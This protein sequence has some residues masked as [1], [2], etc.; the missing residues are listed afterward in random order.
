MRKTIGLLALLSLLAPLSIH[1]TA[2]PET[3]ATN[4][5]ASSTI[6]VSQILGIEEEPTATRPATQL[7]S[8][9]QGMSADRTSTPPKWC[10]LS[11][12]V[13]STTCPAGEGNCT[14]LRCL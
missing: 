4:A 1:A 8:F 14:S 3:A 2:L 6:A 7:D 13:C 10:S 5:S 9:F 11:C 12:R